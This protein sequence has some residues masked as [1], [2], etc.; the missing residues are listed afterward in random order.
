VIKI[1]GG[2][3]YGN[4]EQGLLVRLS[5]KVT[6]DGAA[7]FGNMRQGVRIEGTTYII[8]KNSTIRD[9][10]QAATADLPYD[11]INIRRRE[12]TLI[13]GRIDRA[14]D[15]QILNNDISSDGTPAARQGFREETSHDDGNPLTVT[16]INDNDVQSMLSGHILIQAR[17]R[18]DSAL[19]ATI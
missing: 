17:K 2:S 15:S 19:L 12:D 1:I 8:A 16:L 9:N 14:T 6:I 10:G 11:G 7:I 5:D 3:Y 13:T 4:E 18:S